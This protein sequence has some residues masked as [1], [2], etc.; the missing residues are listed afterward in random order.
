M[1]SVCNTD[2]EEQSQSI[3]TK[4]RYLQDHPTGGAVTFN[5]FQVLYWPLKLQKR[6]G[7][8]SMLNGLINFTYF[9]IAKMK[10]LCVAGQL[11]LED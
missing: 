3:E 9:T 6:A 7:S 8:Q 5:H 11:R 2:E 4:L 1:F 10:F